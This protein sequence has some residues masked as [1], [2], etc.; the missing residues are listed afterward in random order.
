MDN[1]SNGNVHTDKG[2]CGS[3]G[4]T[5]GATISQQSSADRMI[6]DMNRI[7]EYASMAASRLADKVESICIPLEE[8]KKDCV[9][10]PRPPLP[11][12]YSNIYNICESIEDL[13]ADIN[14]II[15]RIDL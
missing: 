13:I 14:A 10:R 4:K 9:L 11:P 7:A 5:V 3:I 15:D 1:M 8:D 12:F 6:A 2:F